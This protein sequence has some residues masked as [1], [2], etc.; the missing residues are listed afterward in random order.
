MWTYCI[1]GDTNI[2]SQK[3]KVR[4]IL[5][6]EKKK[7]A[8]FPGKFLNEIWHAEAEYFDNKFLK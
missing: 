5:Y 7:Y 3:S 6:L 4:Q 1:S 2:L 8:T